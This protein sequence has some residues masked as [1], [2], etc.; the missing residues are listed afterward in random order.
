MAN[1]ILKI[2]RDE[3]LRT[4][5]LLPTLDPVTEEYSR[6][7]HH[8]ET[9]AW[10]VATLEH[11]NVDPD[12]ALAPRPVDDTTA[13]AEPVHTPEPEPEPEPVPAPVEEPKEEP[14]TDAVDWEKYRVA[15]RERMAD[16]RI[17]GVDTKELLAKVGATKF[18][19]IPDEELPKLA[20]ALDKALKEK[21]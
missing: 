13:P 1:E 15:L 16:A 17:G 6:V 18:S 3:M 19:T 10:K 8:Y 2:L 11:P 20:A 5:R 7:L 4:A 12:F 21:A 14:T 9:L